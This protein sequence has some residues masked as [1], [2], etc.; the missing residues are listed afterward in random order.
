ME[1][2]VQRFARRVAGAEGQNLKSEISDL[3]FVQA[4]EGVLNLKFEI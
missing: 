3:R 1:G 2:R 4:D